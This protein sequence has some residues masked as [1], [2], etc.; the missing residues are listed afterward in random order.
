MNCDESRA[1]FLAGTATRDE[2]SHLATCV[3]C[4]DHADALQSS[5]RVL[6]DPAF[7]EEPSSEL[8]DRVVGLITGAP[9]GD[10]VAAT[11]TLRWPVAAGAVAAA[12]LA[13]ALWSGFVTNDP[14]WEVALPGTT[15][16]PGASGVVKGWNEESGTRMVVAVDGLPPA[17][18][19]SVYEF[20][21]SE[22]PLHISAGTF[23]VADEVEL[24]VGVTR[25]QFP[26]LWITLET[27]DEDESPS[28]I[29][30]MDTG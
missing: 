1:A 2:M 19:G 25:A 15:N 24:T 23:V 29:N 10:A 21:L 28:G 3:H 13:V 30:V 16:A 6:D 11:R 7:W 18:Q 9:R 20:W 26:R 12:V 27:I 17:P 4:A 22:G 14:D 8:E 5:R